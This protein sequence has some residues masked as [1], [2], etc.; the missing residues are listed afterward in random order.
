[1]LIR[2]SGGLCFQA[3]AGLSRSTRLRLGC[4]QLNYFTV[5]TCV[6]APLI[7]CRCSLSIATSPFAS[8]RLICARLTAV[9]CRL[10]NL[11]R[12]A[13]KR[14]VETEKGKASAGERNEQAPHL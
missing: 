1:M 8:V 9:I 13:N 7:N 5:S 3:V 11:Q 10:D 6:R 14:T 4:R 12:S 2:M